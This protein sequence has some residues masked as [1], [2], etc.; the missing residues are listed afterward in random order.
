[1][2]VA[3]RLKARMGG[4]VAESMGASPANTGAGGPL[5]AMTRGVPGRYDG[6]TRPRDA[7]ILPVSKIEP[8]PDQPRKEFDSEDL[9]LLADSLKA[10][11]QLQPIRVRWH[12][13]R[14]AWLIVSGERRWRA[15][16]IAGL[17]TLLVVE[18]KELDADT[19]LEDQL[20]ENCV[21]ADLKPIE[22]AHAFRALMGRRGYSGRQLA[23][24]LAISHTNVQR[25]LT[26][27]ELPEAVQGQVERGELAPT[28]AAELAKLPGDVRE[29]VA[30]AVV[31][32]GLN[33]SEVGELVSAIRAKRPAPS[34]KPEP[35]AIDL[36]DGTTVRIAWKKA[37]GTDAIKALRLALRQLQQEG[38]GDRAA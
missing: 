11:G 13:G 23:D 36:G 33:R 6:V 5:P 31:A 1:M 35:V 37:N 10:R 8:D 38:Q 34:A 26:L 17:E 3:D 25:A 12:E 19:I 15:A 2:S 4:N 18:A 27:L 14:G 29:E 22:Q 24:K 30:N 20:V 21:R 28:T 32:G 9:Q 16:G 7:M